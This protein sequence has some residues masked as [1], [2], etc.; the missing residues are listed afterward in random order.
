MSQ[1]DPKRPSGS[2]DISELK[3]RLGL[4]KG[5]S[6][7]QPAARANGAG[8]AAG[9]VVPPPGLN[10]PPPPGAKPPGPVIPAASDDPF[11]AMNAMAQI[12]AAQR[13]P[14]I[15]IVNDGKPV[16]SVAASKRGATIAK[17][18]AIALA[19][20]VLGVVIG[21]IAKEGKTYN[22]SLKDVRGINTDVDRLRKKLGELKSA[23]DNSGNIKERKVADEVTAALQAA[24]GELARNNAAVFRAKQNALNADLSGAVL[25]FYS[26]VEQIETMITDHLATAAMEE[27]AIKTGADQLAKLGVKEGDTLAQVG[28][29]YKVALLLTNP[30]EE[31]ANSD[32]Q[33]AR[34]VELGAPLCGA[35]VSS[36]KVADGGACPEGAAP[37][38]F[39]YRFNDTVAWYKGAVHVPGSLSPGEKFPIGQ[40]LLLS[41][42]GTLDALVKTSGATQAE[43]AYFKRLVKLYEKIEATYE[44]A[45]GLSDALKKRGQQGD[46]FTFFL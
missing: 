34:L 33:A 16:E 27:A 32:P 8:A 36:A 22:A 35:D 44:Q 37:V 14:E 29:P 3:A 1:K 38:G 20:L 40:L 9:G 5:A 43:A 21:Q 23:F 41:S 12:G 39:L 42:T 30:A 28:I 11:G 26:Q 7:G 2:R 19:P 6:G 45:Q 46:R 24:K 4:K 13:A 25:G 15:V 17:F 18:A 10:L 31:G